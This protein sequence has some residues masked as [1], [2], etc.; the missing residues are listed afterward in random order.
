MMKTEAS[1]ERSTLRSASPHRNAYKTEFQALKSTFDQPR[2]DGEQKP[3]A[4][5]QNTQ[6]TR[7]RRYG[8][9]VNRIKNIFMQMESGPNDSTGTPS[10]AKGKLG[11]SPQ[12][13][14]KPK[15]FVDGSI[16]KV[17]T[18]VGKQVSKCDTRRD[19]PCHSKFSETR[20][21]FEQTSRTTSLNKDR[22]GSQECLDDW[23]VS[24][25]NRS[26]TDSLDSLCSRTEASSPTVSQLSAVFE[27][28]QQQNGSMLEK[29][30][31]G[32]H[33]KL[34]EEDSSPQQT[35]AQRNQDFV[36]RKQRIPPSSSS[37]DLLS[38]SPLSDK[39]EE[40]G[41]LGTGGQD[42]NEFVLSNTVDLDALNSTRP[43]GTVTDTECP[44]SQCPDLQDK[45][46]TDFSSTWVT[47]D[48][49]NDL[50]VGYAENK[51]IVDTPDRDIYNQGW[52]ESYTEPEDQEGS[53]ESNYYEL[54]NSTWEIPG[55]PE[56]E[57]EE[58][59]EE[60]PSNRKIRFSTAPIKVFNTY[61]NEDYDRRNEEVDPVAA[62]AE[63]E[64]E[65]RVERLD[66]FPVELEKDEE[67]LGISIIGMGVGADAGLEKLGI[68]IKTVI[69]GG[70]AHRHDRIQV[71][72]QIVEVDGISLVGVT[73][74]FAAAV[75]RNT[76]GTVRFLIGREKPGQT[77]E[78]A[79]LISQTLE[80]ERRQR[81]MMEQQYAQYD[82]DDDETGEYATDG[83]EDDTAPELK[84]AE[85]AIE[86]FDLP[87]TEDMFSPTELDTTKLSH[88]FRELQ[89]K[90]AVTEAEIQKL[91]HKLQTA[92][93]E[94]VR[95]E[96]EKN[97]LKQSIED[98]KSRM[99]Q[100][101]SYWIEAQTLCHTVNEHLKETQ[102][103]YQALEKKYNK[104]KK[105]IKD[106]QQKELDFVK[107]EE[108][109]R[110]KFED[111][112]R[113]HLVE[114]KGLQTRISDLE[115][116]LFRLMKQNVTQVNNNNNIA[117]SRSS[118]GVVRRGPSE[119]A[120]ECLEGRQKSC[121][122]G[123]NG[124]FNEAVPET[125]RLDS[126]VL[127]ARVQLSVKSKRHRPSRA[128]LRDSV[129]STDGEDSLERRALAGSGS[130]LLSARSPLPVTLRTCSAASDSGASS[131]SPVA[132]SSEYTPEN[133][134]E[135][136]EHRHPQQ[137]KEREDLHSPLLSSP[138][139]GQEEKAKRKL[140]DLGA[141]Q[142]WSSGNGNKRR[143][144]DKE[145]KRLSS[146]SRA[147]K[148]T[149]EHSVSTTSSEGATSSPR[150]PCVPLPWFGEGAKYSTSSSNFPSPTSS[151]EPSYENSPEKHKTKILDEGQSPKHNQWQNR[152]VLEWS[153]KQVSHWLM[154]L[155]LE[156]YIPE[157]TAKNIDG[158]QLLQLDGSKLKSLGITTSQDQVL[159]K[160]KIKDLRVYMEKARKTRE[161]L[162]KLRKKEQGHLKKQAKAD[163]P[164]A[165][166]TE[167]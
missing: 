126:N 133:Q 17:V 50:H 108:V 35:Q 54:D 140:I 42:E 122:A 53:D 163:K 132:L 104:A 127:K 21:M 44:L 90:H 128:R 46:G 14:Q 165:G 162:E 62:S 20:K 29:S 117:E 1:G 86:V 81:E 72:D 102:S 56:E 37:E 11:T 114:I 113:A 111:T 76:K 22:K 52:G 118:H 98:N 91:K 55:L 63:Y 94:K 12:K 84:G 25:S 24:R 120:I 5:T 82:A 144:N 39:T 45:S 38:S 8:S 146:G 112:E 95:W 167:H 107:R 143:E 93:S 134:K 159:L 155:N 103:Q 136:Q 164:L 85:M 78:V 139:L 67:G 141:P 3:K 57:E 80:Q 13:I 99:L 166:P 28:A 148:E 27:N 16:V 87:E 69:E 106:F 145:A 135:G 89:I 70:A 129:S 149:Q 125:E 158:E 97:Q 152:T 147:S 43:V 156:Q 60:I 150:R 74:N 73:Q 71:N 19:G 64:L 101:E 36:E 160:K 100:L 23:R 9:N 47:D 142:R 7:G 32:G 154:G 92:E 115:R 123:P 153:C 33:N 88:K 31:D 26:S 131:L 68:F 40:M 66:L 105:L 48:Q 41:Q 138:S 137:S 124:D 6:Q 65:K 161:K 119:E 15:D 109:E 110:K 34:S 130:P 51:K 77:S 61:S 10:K 2:I 121:Q 30:D 49:V 4:G 18:T 116:E 75:L 58:K 151:T 59:E 83:E 96:C 157:F 79:H